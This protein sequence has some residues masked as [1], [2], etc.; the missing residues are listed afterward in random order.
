MGKRFRGIMLLVVLFTAFCGLIFVPSYG[1]AHD[2]PRG[3][4]ISSWMAGSKHFP[5]IL[6]RVKN[7][8]INTLVIDFKDATGKVT[9]ATN[10]KLVKMIGSRE[11]RIRSKR[12]QWI[13]DECKK[14]DIH[15]I[16]RIVIAKDPVLSKFQNSKF[17]I[18]GKGGKSSIWVDVSSSFVQDYNIGIAN[19]LLVMG[20]DEINFDYIRYPDG[21]EVRSSSCPYWEK[22]GEGRS[23]AYGVELFLKKA[24]ANLDG[25]ISV[26]VY[27]Y[28]VWGTEEKH[29]SQK[30]NPIGQVIE[31]M[32]KHVDCIYPMVY[33]SHFPRGDYRGIAACQPDKPGEYTIINESCKRGIRRLKGTNVKIIPWIQG[34]KWRAPNYGVDYVRNQAEGSADAGSPGFFIWNPSN[35]Y[36]EAWEIWG[37]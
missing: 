19:E 13:I 12:L 3:I 8:R 21:I 7:S 18:K 24:R 28:T 26:D 10:S 6:E 36:Y 37:K 2:N 29:L 31:L 17:A 34:F 23:V 32:A 9:F 14:N 35:K 25:L 33:P 4:Y 15:L 5:N 11:V 30:H 22:I 20:F 1:H 16:A 27:G